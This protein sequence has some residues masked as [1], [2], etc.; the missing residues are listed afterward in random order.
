MTAKWSRRG[1]AELSS[2][3]AAAGFLRHQL[4][5][6]PVPD[7]LKIFVATGAEFHDMVVA[8]VFSAIRY[9]RISPLAVVFRRNGRDPRWPYD[10]ASRPFLHQDE[11]DRLLCAGVRPAA[12]SASRPAVPCC[13]RCREHLSR[14]G[15][16]GLDEADPQ[17]GDVLRLHGGAQRGRLAEHL[18]GLLDRFQAVGRASLTFLFAAANIPMLLRHGLMKEDAVPAEP[19]PVE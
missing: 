15:P 16:G 5:R 14:L 7:V 6:A 3:L 11:A 8:I 13:S 12:A 18:V 10:L 2:I 4:P 19:G 17:L 9:H 1:S